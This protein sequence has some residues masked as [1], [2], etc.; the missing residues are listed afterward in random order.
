MPRA[1]LRFRLDV[2]MALR[3]LVD[4]P[5]RSVLTLLGIVIGIL[6]LTVMM[7]LIGALQ[8]SVNDALLPLGVGVFQAQK[9]PTGGH[10]NVDAALI[11]KRKNLIYSDLEELRSRLTLTEAVGGEAWGW[12]IAIK[13][14]KHAMTPNCGMAGMTPAFLAANSMDLEL[15]R[16]I[17]TRDLDTARNVAVI[18]ADI[19][20]TLFPEG[21][22]AALG[23]TIRVGNKPFTVVGTMEEKPV[24]FGA[25]W[26]NC[27]VAI[28]LT[29]YLRDFGRPSLHVTFLAKDRYN[30]KPA[31]EEARLAI[32]TMHRLKSDEP[33]DFD[34][35]D[36]ESEGAELQ[37]FAL[38]ITAAAG[39]ICLIALLVGGVGVMNIMLVSVMER[40]REIGV[41]KALGARPA[42]ILGQFMT[43]AV[44]LT[45][46]GGVVGVVLAYAVVMA[47]GA[48][49]DLPATVPLW[50]VALA[51][52]SSAGVGLAAGIYPA[53]RAAKMP[54]IEALRYE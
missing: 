23:S 27:L 2:E 13:N 35:F 49:L 53:A 36:N 51:L 47:G 37:G 22:S 10:N 44:V 3:T 31:Q 21:A 17:N 38:A 12:G 34:M 14:E 30:P 4:R 28:P 45:G 48:L 5:G 32:R 24:L 19:V 8:S 15:G 1:L 6:A 25:A 7:A 42:A 50:T 39:A 16:T 29:A 40:T 33:D 26:R 20:K 43:E 11:A 9:E 54:P 18:G 46:V 52:I 41:R